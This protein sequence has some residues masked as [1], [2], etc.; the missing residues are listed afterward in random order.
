MKTYVVTGVTQGIGKTIKEILLEN[1]YR[2]IGIDK[3]EDESAQELQEKYAE[4]YAFH[5]FDLADRSAVAD[6]VTH[7]DEVLDGIVNNAGEIYFN[8]WETFDQNLWDRTLEVNLTSVVSL[9]HGLY[10]KIRSGG[11][12]VN[13]TSVDG[14]LAAFDTI[15]YAVS[16]AGLINLTKSLGAVLGPKGIRVN[17]IAPGWVETNMTKD[18]IPEITKEMTPLKRNATTRDIAQLVEF[19]LSE[20]SSFINAQTIT[21]DGGLFSVD[22]TLWKEAKNNFEK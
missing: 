18:T 14:T 10:T 8:S 16:K 17:A 11:S 13:I 7:F 20:K 9:V 15:A 5:L 21:A 19:L 2:V 4:R 3:Q 22:Y 1:G 12:I 6:F